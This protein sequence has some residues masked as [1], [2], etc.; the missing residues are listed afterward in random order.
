MAGGTRRTATW[1][2]SKV[3]A[4]NQ[5]ELLRRYGFR[6]HEKR[7]HA[8]W[9]LD[10]MENAGAFVAAVEGL[11]GTHMPVGAKRM[12]SPGRVAPDSNGND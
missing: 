9:Q 1:Y 3:M 2:V 7:D 8:W 12:A 6:W 5:E 11:T 4:R 10:G